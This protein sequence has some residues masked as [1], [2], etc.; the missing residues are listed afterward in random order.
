MRYG[1]GIIINLHYFLVVTLLHFLAQQYCSLVSVVVLLHFPTQQV[2][3]LVAMESLYLPSLLLLS[4]SPRPMPTSTVLLHLYQVL[5]PLSSYISTGT[6]GPGRNTN[7]LFSSK[8]KPRL[9]SCCT[10]A[11]LLK[12]NKHS[13]RRMLQCLFAFR[14]ITQHA[15]FCFQV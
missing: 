9:A 13:W 12:H 1:S 6:N 10:F 3:Y 8:S 15:R 11:W 5:F 14:K 4:S 2:C 7:W